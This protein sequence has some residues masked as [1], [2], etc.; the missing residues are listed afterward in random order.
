VATFLITGPSV[1]AHQSA[2]SAKPKLGGTLSIRISGQP[3][4]MD[5]AKLNSGNGYSL[6]NWI[7]DTLLATTPAH[8]HIIPYLAQSYTVAK[9]GTTITFHLRHDVKFSDGHPLTSAD[10]KAS[11][12]RI[13]DP[14]TKSPIANG[15]LNSISSVMTPDKY[16]AVLHLSTPS[17]PLLNNLTSVYGGIIEKS[18]IAAAGTSSCTRGLIGS[19]PF[20]LESASPDLTSVTEVRNKYHTFGPKYSLNKGPAYLGG[21]H[22]QSIT[23]D[24]TAV[25]A[26]LA[27][28][29]DV[30]DMPADQ[31]PRVQGNSSVKLVKTARQG[32]YFMLFNDSHAPFTNQK[33]RVAVAQAINRAAIITGVAGGLGK[34]AYT[35]VPPGAFAFDTKAKTY[36]PKFNQSA[37]RKAIAA[38]GATGP[39]SLVVGNDPTDQQ[40]ALLLQAQL[41]AVGMRI[42]INAVDQAGYVAALFSGH[43]DITTIDAYYNDPDLLYIFYNSSQAGNGLDFTHFTS[44]KL[45]KLTLDGRQTLNLKKAKADYLAAQKLIV[46]Q[47]LSIQLYTPFGITGLRSRVQG[48]KIYPGGISGLVNIQDVWLK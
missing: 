1:L 5:P 14:A 26:L 43:F 36:A 27:G 37:A 46:T 12:D 21:V 29:L 8:P 34:P 31:L 35:P 22:F 40:L 20:K 18:S 15:L 28:Q 7:F 44:A 39:Y 47:A 6:A 11:F 42:T 13:L 3:D 17:R 32:S 25:S 48:Y 41:A 2:A 9:S 45:D 19:G 23:S 38:A 16:T 33:V 30:A 10:V 24:T 4:C